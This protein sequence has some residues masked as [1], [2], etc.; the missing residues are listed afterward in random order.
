VHVLAGRAV[1]VPAANGSLYLLAV[2]AGEG[3]TVLGDGG[4]DLC[5]ETGVLAPLLD[6]LVLLVAPPA[7]KELDRG[8]GLVDGE[9]VPM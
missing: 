3:R 9:V 7:G 2:L 5:V 8:P 6:L 1:L 4:E